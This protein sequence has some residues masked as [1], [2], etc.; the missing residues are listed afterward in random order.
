MK[1][2]SIILSIWLSCTTLCAQS[3]H[4][5]PTDS[6][7]EANNVGVVAQENQTATFSKEEG[8]EAFAS[9]DFRGAIMIYQQIIENQ[10]VSAELYYNLGNSYF[11]VDEIAKAIVH[12]ERALLLDPSDKDILFNLELARAKTVDK[13][14]PQPKI[15][16]VTWYNSITNSLSEKAWATLGIFLFVAFLLLF[17]TYLVAKSLLIRKIAFIKGAVLLLL[18]LLANIFA[19]HQKSE[20]LNQNNA[21]IM[22]PSV[23][24]KSTPNAGGTDLFIIHEGRKVMI[25]DNSM[26]AWKEIELEDGHVG[27]VTTEALEII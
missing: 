26:K 14:V 15:F 22:Q 18:C 25:K 3:N 19:N 17:T 8:D 12:F 13:V 21:I 16:L 9:N 4:T 24:V 5:L 2:L 1:K 23:T 7:Q 11:K 6:L 27:W 20:L 10:G